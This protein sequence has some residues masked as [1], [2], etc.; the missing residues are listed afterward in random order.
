MEK[1]KCNSCLIEKDL[2]SFYKSKQSKYGISKVCKL[3]KNQGR[4]SAKINTTIHPF[5]R[6]FRKSES[7]WYSMAG[8][9]K[10]DY[11]DMWSLLAKMG[12]DV[13][14]DVHQQFLDKHNVNE[15]SPMK[16][17]HRACNFVS[18]ILPNGEV[19]PESKPGRYKKTPTE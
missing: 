3:C 6:E 9:T 16:Y 12:Y 10:K 4:K 17:K 8:C 18:Y 14:K 19:N 13:S 1:I 11:M 5:N 2:T 15:K 7:N